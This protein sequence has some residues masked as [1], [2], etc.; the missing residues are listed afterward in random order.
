MRAIE[1][2]YPWGHSLLWRPLTSLAGQH[3]P[4]LASVPCMVCARPPTRPTHDPTPALDLGRGRPWPTTCPPPHR[5]NAWT[6]AA[7]PAQ[8]T[9]C[10]HRPAVQRLTP[11][12]LLAYMGGVEHRLCEIQTSCSGIVLR[13]RRRRSPTKLA[14][15]SPNP[16][17]TFVL[18]PVLAGPRPRRPPSRRTPPVPRLTPRQGLTLS[19]THGL[20]RPWRRRPQTRR[21]RNESDLPK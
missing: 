17:I 5:W 11:G 7:M 20:P 15:S 18:A 9:R 4:G 8:P 3:V 10:R 13:R 12:S 21:C 2:A 19:P 6:S 16:W 14:N 1:Q